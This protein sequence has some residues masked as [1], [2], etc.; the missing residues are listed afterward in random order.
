MGRAFRLVRLSLGAALCAGWVGIWFVVFKQALD[1]SR[2]NDGPSRAAA[3]L[4]G[5]YATPL[6]LWGLPLVVTGLPRRLDPGARLG[7]GRVLMQIACY[8]LAALF[9]LFSIVFARFVGTGAGAEILFLASLG[10]AAVCVLSGK[11][12]GR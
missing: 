8:S 5:W 2:Y 11:R 7:A 6:L 4:I 10:T 1:D 9:G 3:L 12:V